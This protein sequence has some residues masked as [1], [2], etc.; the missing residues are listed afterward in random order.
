MRRNARVDINQLDITQALR[1]CGAQVLPLHMIGRGCPDILVK[2][3]R[4]GLH[5]CEIK[6][7]KRKWKLEDDQKEFHAQWSPIV[8]LTSVEDAI[9][10][11][12]QQAHQ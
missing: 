8:I 9:A 6:N 10:W 5:L 12:N 11:I 7:G 2:L 4:G 1:K 3:P